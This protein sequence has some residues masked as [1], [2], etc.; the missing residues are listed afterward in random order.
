MPK[1]ARTEVVIFRLRRSHFDK[2][3]EDHSSQKLRSINTEDQF[4]RK[5]I[6]DYLIGKLVYTNPADRQVTP[7]G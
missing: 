6:I 3:V 7:E 2:L 5:I 1:E 4:A